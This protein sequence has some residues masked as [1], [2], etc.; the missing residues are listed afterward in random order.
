MVLTCKHG[1]FIVGNEPTDSDLALAPKLRHTRVALGHYMS[2][3]LIQKGSKCIYGVSKQLQTAFEGLDERVDCLQV[4][5]ADEYNLGWK[6]MKNHLDQERAKESGGNGG[7]GGGEMVSLAK[8][9]V[10]ER[11]QGCMASAEHG[12]GFQVEFLHPEAIA[13]YD[14]TTMDSLDCLSKEHFQ[15]IVPFTI[16]PGFKSEGSIVIKSRVYLQPK[17]STVHLGC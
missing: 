5:L 15:P 17:H 12:R 8:E 16:F 1:P 2:F 9:R 7:L 3:K 4:S 13:K 14:E 10:R 11:V 6:K